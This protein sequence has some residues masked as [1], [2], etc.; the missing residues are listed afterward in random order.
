M[1]NEPV[2]S[3]IGI[4]LVSSKNTSITRILS[5]GNISEETPWKVRTLKF[6]S[7]DEYGNHTSSIN[8]GSQAYFTISIKNDFNKSLP[9]LIAVN[10]LN[11]YNESIGQMSACGIV[12]P[13]FTILYIGAVY[14]PYDTYNGTATAFAS[15]FS[16][17]PS[18]NGLP[19]YPEQH[20][21]FDILEGIIPVL[22]PVSYCNMTLQ[23]DY[24]HVL[25]LSADY[26]F[27]TGQRTSRQSTRP[28]PHSPKH[29]F[30]TPSYATSAAT[31][32]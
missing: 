9:F 13:N 3:L 7:S 26:R 31:E 14:I 1:E 22:K 6:Y 25:N 18:S 19:Y 4:E 29:R 16:D 24:M 21:F 8:V 32:K 20:V 5:Y 23:S 30:S 27:G 15:V 17:R 10:V 28:R 12:Q 11:K 2:T